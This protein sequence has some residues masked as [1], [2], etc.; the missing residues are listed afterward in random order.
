[1]VEQPA[2]V[3]V[4]LRLRE[5]F[6]RPGR[7]ALVHVAEGANGGAGGDA[8]QVAA[9]AALGA[10]DADNEAFTGRLLLLGGGEQG[11]GERPR[12]GGVQELAAGQAWHG[13][14]P[15]ARGGKS[16]V[17]RCRPACAR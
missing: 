15:G 10:D 5:L 7:A 13:G 8:G 12:G 14:S 4:E 16:L 3:G 11:G 6:A 2:E 1:L 9:A 17:I